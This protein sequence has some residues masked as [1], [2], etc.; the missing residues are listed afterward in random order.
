MIKCKMHQDDQDSINFDVEI[1]GKSEDVLIELMQI[2]AVL[3]RNYRK[4]GFTDK[5]IEK[6][7]IGCVAAGF[8]MEDSHK[9]KKP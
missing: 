4:A 5:N 9:K 2:N 7:L 1:V 3:I 6:Q 8:A